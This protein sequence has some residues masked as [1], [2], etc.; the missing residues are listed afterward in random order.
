MRGMSTRYRHDP[1]NFKYVSRLSHI[2]SMK[3]INLNR[4]RNNLAVLFKE[5][6]KAILVILKFWFCGVT[7]TNV[8]H[9]VLPHSFLVFFRANAKKGIIFE[10]LPFLLLYAKN[11]HQREFLAGFEKNARFQMHFSKGSYIL[12]SHGIL[13]RRYQ[14]LNSSTVSF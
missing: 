1:F 4:W 2:K 7:S 9:W 3:N 14:E 12:R 5:S 8:D 11:S 10:F 6:K 13:Y